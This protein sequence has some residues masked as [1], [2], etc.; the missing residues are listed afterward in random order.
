MDSIYCH[1]NKL[2]MSDLSGKIRRGLKWSAI[3]RIVTQTI[4][5]G[6][7]LVLA[8]ML[9]PEAFGLIGMLAVFI[10]ISNVFIDSGFTAALIRKL[11]CDEN[12]LTTAFTYN[13]SI[14]ALCYFILYVSSPF[15]SIFFHQPELQTLLRA[16]GANVVIN[17][18][19]LIPRVVLTAN[20]K[21]DAL[22]KASVISALLSGVLAI[23][24]AQQKLGPW[25]LVVQSLVNTTC[26][27]LLLSFFFPWLPRGT[28]NK[29]SFSYLFG[30][31][32]K[33]LFASLLDVLYTNIY[34][35]IIGKKFIPSVVGQYTQANQLSS[36]PAMTLTG[37]IQR[38]TYPIFAQ[39]QD[40][41]CS[42]EKAYRLTLRISA[43][44]VFPL[45]VGLAII[46]QPLLVFLL[47]AEWYSAAKML[48]VLCFGYMLYPIHA[49]NLNL[50]QVKGRSDLFL[51]L[52]LI[53]KGLGV[54]I[55][56]ISIPFGVLAM[57]VGVTIASYLS[58]VI[59]CYY[60]AKL[61]TISQW[62][63]CRDVL[64]IWL[65]V[66]ASSIISYHVGLIFHADPL[67]EILT[68]LSTAMIIYFGY[69][70]LWQRDVI[71]HL[72]KC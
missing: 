48:S 52:E 45:L 2:A 42:I 60:T 27:A 44:V 55:L 18:F 49:V 66:I 63:Q 34:T 13:I 6:L 19:T 22:A 38:V 50:L 68:S 67:I 12:D 8:R 70:F 31:G 32:S 5:L 25:A 61:T 51:K 59:N 71:S 17:A 53:K 26:C 41:K 40:D 57:C 58:L 69:L 36:T 15:I 28:I 47:G 65:A 23:F 11:D 46:A 33:L 72:L 37:I 39:L 4:Q 24:I 54:G 56:L 14:S 21:F 43:A 35:V 3:E 10:A 62:E 1:W 16:L 7:T 64:P 20:M 9:G 30:F 29:K